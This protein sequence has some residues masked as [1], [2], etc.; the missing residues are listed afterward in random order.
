MY[1]PRVMI[2]EQDGSVAASMARQFKVSGWEVVVTQPHEVVELAAAHRPD[3]VLL[4]AENDGV[5]LCAQ[6]HAR[7][8]EIRVAMM[9]MPGHAPE[10]AN[11]CV[12]AG[13]FVFLEMPLKLTSIA[14]LK[15]VLQT[16]HS[17][18]RVLIS[19]DDSLM[20][21]AL[22]RAARHEGLEPV[23]ETDAT[24]VVDL[25]KQVHPEFIVLDIKQKNCDGRDVLA[26]LKRD[27]ATKDI[28]VVMLT[29]VEDQLCRHDC[30]AMGAEDYVVKPLDPLFFVRLARKLAAPVAV[31]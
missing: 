28:R 4:D 24:H 23:S 22:E 10:L 12:A 21:R 14:A 9:A 11:R 30:F 27:P 7:A 8:K 31:A 3:V 15:K 19:D 20:V 18:P 13:A 17:A 29:G 16:V 1:T 25:A 26:Q 6:L 2:A 5:E